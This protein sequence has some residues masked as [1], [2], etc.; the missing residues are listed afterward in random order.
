MNIYEALNTVSWKKKEYFLWKHNLSVLREVPLTEEEICNKIKSKSLSYMKKWEKT[1]EYHNLV[2][3]MIESQAGKDLEDIYA[4]VKEKALTGDEKSIKLL[5]D[6][7]KQVQI[8]NKQSTKVNKS[9]SNTYDDL[10]LE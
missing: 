7:Q 3:I 6:L 5:L 10:E 9:T 1:E 4:I 8:H 2:N